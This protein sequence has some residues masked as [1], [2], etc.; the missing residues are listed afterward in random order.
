VITTS[1]RRPVALLTLIAAL[2]AALALTASPAHATAYRFWSYWQGAGGQWV[3][4]QTGPADYQV[5]DSDVQ[6]WRFGITVAMPQT[7]PD[8]APDFAALCPD[9]AAGDAP[10]G[11]VR[12]AVVIDP[13]FTA[14]APQG[15]T[16][17]VDRIACVTVPEGSTGSQALSA[18][19]SVTEQSG[20]VCAIDAYPS[21]ECSATVSDAD[22]AAAASAAATEPPNPAVVASDGASAPGSPATPVG[23]IAALAALIAVA[24]TALVLNRRRAAAIAEPRPAGDPHDPQRGPESE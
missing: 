2:A 8:N 18:A 16:P 13:G 4:A 23:L 20:M 21:G 19:G 6:G 3:A 12:V 1:P 17:P 24:G 14:D 5:V 15:Q 10:S 7:P 9:L 22:A 11:Q